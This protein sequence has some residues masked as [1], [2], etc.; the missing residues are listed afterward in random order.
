MN[1]TYI[2]NE[3]YKGLNEVLRSNRIFN[4]VKLKKTLKTINLN[5]KF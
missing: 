4:D 3:L 5:F 1:S 2:K